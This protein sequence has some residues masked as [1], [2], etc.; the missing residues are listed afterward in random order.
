M[1]FVRWL[2]EIRIGDL[3]WAGEK[4]ATLGEL[5]GRGYEVPRGFCITAEGC[6]S[7]LSMNRIQ[8]RVA[9]RLAKIEIDDPIEL[10][11]AAE[12]IRAWIENVPLPPDVD[13]EI[14]QAVNVLAPAPEQSP[15]A[16][17]TSRLFEDLPNTSASGLPQAW[18]AVK[19]PGIVDY[20]CKCWAAPWSSGAIYYR[21]RKKIDPGR[22]MIGVIVQKLVQA[23]T[24]GVMFTA[25]PL[26]GVEAEIHIEGTV[27]LGEA[28]VAAR[29]K[30]D[31]WV[32]SK[33]GLESSGE[34]IRERSIAVKA[35]M[36]VA[37][38]EG[39][40]QSVAVPEEKQAAAC[41]TDRQ[42]VDLARLGLQIERDFSQPQVVEW[43]IAGDKTYV[44]QSRGMK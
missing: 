30:G 3:P 17:R 20:V 21:H 28:I 40:L 12:E 1:A 44:L 15:L 27:G 13:S 26:T 25:D 19:S 6:R 5:A 43:C 39:G 22:V 38:P 35:V 7:A 36:D 24:S 16:V 33:K 31:H 29:T 42:A 4:A 32:V 41:L 10:E 11:E 37:S 8:S 18:L 23:D 2:N 34:A 9:A 14:L